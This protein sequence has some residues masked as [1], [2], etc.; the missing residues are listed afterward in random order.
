MT[1]LPELRRAV[2]SYK[3]AQSTLRDA[4]WAL[5][6][7]RNQLFKPGQPVRV[8]SARYKGFGVVVKEQTDPSMLPVKLENGNVWWY[9]VEDC[10]ARTW[11]QVNVLD[12][13]LRRAY[14]RWHGRQTFRGPQG[15]LP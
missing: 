15:A 1:L 14:L 9:P 6:E 10:Q 4:S 7:I 5:R 8:Y 12:P 3:A 2:I 13:S 11:G